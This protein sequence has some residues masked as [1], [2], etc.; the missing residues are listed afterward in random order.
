MDIE[1]SNFLCTNQECRGVNHLHVMDL[2]DKEVLLIC[3]DCG[4]RVIGRK[5]K[6]E[7]N[8]PNET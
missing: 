3:Q 8:R 5:T 2:P 1:V 6:T 4:K 7:G